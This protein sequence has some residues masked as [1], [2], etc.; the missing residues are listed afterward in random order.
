M[1]LNGKKV[2][3]LGY[4]KTGKAC[5]KT[6]L[7]LGAKVKVSDKNPDIGI[8]EGIEVELGGHS[9]EFVL[10]SDIIVLSPGV[11]WD[12]PVLEVARKKGIETISEVEL[13]YRLIDTPII[14]ITGTNGKTT[15]TSLTAHI[16]SSEKKVKLVGNIGIPFIQEIFD[17]SSE[18]FV[19]E[20]SSFQ[21]Q[22]TKFFRP[23]IGVLL[24]I[25]S[26]HLNWHNSMEEYIEAKKKLFSNQAGDDILIY[27]KDDKNVLN[28]VEDARGRK[29]SF[30]LEEKGDIYLDG[31]FVRFN[32][33]EFS[34]ISIS[35]NGI[36]LVG[37][38]NIGN[39]MCA[40]AIGLLCG[41]SPQD[42]EQAIR[43]FT[44]YP[45]TLEKFLEYDGLI[46]INDSKAT[47]PHATISALKSIDGPK[48]LILGGQDKG[49]DFSGL[50]DEIKMTQVKYVFLIGE[51]RHKLKELL[52]ENGLYNFSVY[53][54]L[55]E[56]VESAIK[57]AKRGDCILFSP[58]C[59]SFDMF[60]N[61]K[62]RG[63]RFKEIVTRWKDNK[64]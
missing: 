60:K 46:F 50:I 55:E 22:G 5:L 17:R 54:S 1:D 64:G 57:L 40:S 20:V 10:D 32:I 62:D 39:I 13:A 24:N 38:H 30:S 18:Y 51:T 33:P 2:T 41:I 36:K 12:E 6:L 63:E 28:A 49:M 52:I 7:T 34:D 58:A 29:I 47:N 9:E 26:D 48:L 61:Y 31:N 35:L 23:K 45:H 3:I 56:T 43:T 11:R 19:L 8:P 16:L 21:L 53:E 44:P 37:R 4:G 25:A 42:I 14:A 59:A 15:T 27:N